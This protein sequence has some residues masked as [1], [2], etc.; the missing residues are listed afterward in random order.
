MAF[1]IGSVVLC[2]HDF[3]DMEEVQHVLGAARE[4]KFFAVE[5]VARTEDKPHGELITIGNVQLRSYTTKPLLRAAMDTL[6][7]LVGK[8]TTRDRTLTITTT[9]G[10][11]VTF[12]RCT[13]TG[14][15]ETMSAV[16]YYE[17]TALRWKSKVDVEFTRLINS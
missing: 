11:T 17:G 8:T 1:T 5:G 12:T 7:R 6:R 4:G 13:L 10:G 14:V 15:N 3:H 9:N 2:N 16:S